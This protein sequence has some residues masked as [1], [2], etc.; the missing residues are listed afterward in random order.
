MVWLIE[1]NG[2]ER[3]A[4]GTGTG[5][6]GAGVVAEA[7]LPAYIDEWRAGQASSTRQAL[8]ALVF[9]LVLARLPLVEIELAA[10]HA[11]VV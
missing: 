3:G 2:R 8:H 5:G 7:T 6:Q 11:C 9:M 1:S 4:G 10:V